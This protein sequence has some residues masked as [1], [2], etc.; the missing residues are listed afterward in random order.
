MLLAISMNQSAGS[1]R[2]A[3][4]AVSDEKSGTEMMQATRDA[5]M[6]TPMA[7]VL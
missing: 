3:S 7:N 4:D 5:D 6:P 1:T 2:W